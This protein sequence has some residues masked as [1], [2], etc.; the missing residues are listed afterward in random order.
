[1]S[2][3]K[4]DFLLY[5]LKAIFIPETFREFFIPR[6]TSAYLIRVAILC[7]FCLVFFGIFF[8][9]ALIRGGSMEPTYHS[10]GVNL[11]NR[12]K[13][14]HKEPRR[15]D[16]VAIR[17]DDRIMYLKR[18]VGLPGETVEFRDGKLYIN[19]KPL[20]EP[21]VKYPCDW[22]LEPRQVD[23]GYYYVVGDNRSQPIRQHKFGKVSRRRIIGAPLW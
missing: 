8:T 1:M 15:G 14:R 19:G 12:F 11:V 7:V 3:Y 10:L 2:G 5:R 20:D 21:Y 22:K 18:V 23:S 9:P 16:I 13:F 6:I 17:Y 4:F